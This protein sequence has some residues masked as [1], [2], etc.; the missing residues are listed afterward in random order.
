MIQNAK[1]CMQRL[2]ASLLAVFVLAGALLS[3]V[4]PVQAA[5]ANVGK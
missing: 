4:M 3:Y 1:Q 2:S 5:I